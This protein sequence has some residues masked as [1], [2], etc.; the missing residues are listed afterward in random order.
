MPTDRLTNKNSLVERLRADAI[1]G[2]L[3]MHDADCLVCQAADEIERLTADAARYHWLRE[4]GFSCS[5]PTDEA[6]E[7]SFTPTDSPSVVDEAIDSFMRGS[8]P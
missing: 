3:G 7:W 8:T 5:D 6:A 1:H 4:H 2:H